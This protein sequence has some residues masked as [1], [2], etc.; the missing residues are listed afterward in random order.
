MTDYNWH[1]QVGGGNPESGHHWISA[2][3]KGISIF[4]IDKMTAQMKRDER[5]IHVRMITTN[6]TRHCQWR[7][8]MSGYSMLPPHLRF[9]VLLDLVCVINDLYCTVLYTCLFSV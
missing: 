6:T 5:D 1:Y 2:P 3:V 8:I 7:Y 9:D 4:V